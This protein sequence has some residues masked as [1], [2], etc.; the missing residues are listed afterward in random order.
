MSIDCKRYVGY[1]MDVLD[2]LD[3]MSDENRD[4]FIY[5]LNV[6][7]DKI[8]FVSDNRAERGNITL[9]YDGLNGDYC[10]LMYVLACDGGYEDEEPHVQDEINNLLSKLPV[11]TDIAMSMHKAYEY[12]FGRKTTRVIK[13]EYVIHYS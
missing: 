7:V 3:F 1:V 2:D 9:I 8:S 13:P 11:D 12:I 6:S 4:K 10:K 5:G